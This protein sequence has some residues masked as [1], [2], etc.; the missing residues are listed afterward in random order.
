MLQQ[1]ALARRPDALNLVERRGLHRL[2]APR[3]MGADG[4][5]MRLVAELLDAI[6]HGVAR[7]E[8]QRLAPLQIDA[9]APGVAVG[10]LGYRRE[11]DLG[12]PELVEHA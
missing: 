3:A 10:T 6:K 5:A 9:L 1:R 12:E 7:L 4:K 11:L 2:L 8:Q